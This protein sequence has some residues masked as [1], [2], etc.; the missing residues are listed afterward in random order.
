VI[1]D[2]D[3]SLVHEFM[4]NDPHPGKDR[5]SGYFGVTDEGSPVEYRRIAIQELQP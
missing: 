1:L 4:D 5:R 2:A 3:L